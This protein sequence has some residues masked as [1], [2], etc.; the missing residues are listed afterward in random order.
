MFKDSVWD[1]GF[2]KFYSFVEEFYMFQFLYVSFY[3]EMLFFYIWKI[4]N[5][6]VMYMALL[7]VMRMCFRMFRFEFIFVFQE[8]LLNLGYGS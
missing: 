4:I 6:S 5:R 8:N 3:Y 2:L 1:I 7:F